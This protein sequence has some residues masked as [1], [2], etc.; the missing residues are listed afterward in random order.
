MSNFDEES[1]NEVVILMLSSH[2]RFSIAF[3]LHIDTA[4]FFEDG[5]APTLLRPAFASCFSPF[6]L[7]LPPLNNDSYTFSIL[8][9]V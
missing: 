3:P 5:R 4:V 9:Q 8:E 1:F 7:Y 2:C 6:C